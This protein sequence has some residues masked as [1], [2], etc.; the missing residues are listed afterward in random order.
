MDAEADSV[1]LVYKWEGLKPLSVYMD[2]GPPQPRAQGFFRKRCVGAGGGEAGLCC[3]RPRIPRRWTWSQ[4]WQV[5]GQP[6]HP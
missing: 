2:V 6:S 1:W 4:G 5:G 3:A